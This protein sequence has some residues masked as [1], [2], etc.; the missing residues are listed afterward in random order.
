MV[1][2]KI[3]HGDLSL[4]IFP[5]LFASVLCV[6]VCATKVIMYYIFISMRRVWISVI[7]CVCL[8]RWPLAVHLAMAIFNSL[9]SY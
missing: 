9:T 3:T 1:K 5:P 8:G 2:L 6:C 7:S 4:F